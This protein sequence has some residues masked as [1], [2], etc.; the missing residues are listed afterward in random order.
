MPLKRKPLRK[1][2]RDKMN[3]DGK[4]CLNTCAY[5]QF[6][7]CTLFDVRVGY[8]S[9]EEKAKR[10]SKCIYYFKEVK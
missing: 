2:I 4:H 10:C 9:K 6:A 5:K 7:F 3:F 8:S 1:E